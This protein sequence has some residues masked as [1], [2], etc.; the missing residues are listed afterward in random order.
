[1]LAVHLLSEL[2]LAVSH[3]HLWLDSHW[4]CIH[5]KKISSRPVLFTD[6]LF[7]LRK[8]FWMFGRSFELCFLACRYCTAFSSTFNVMVLLDHACCFIFSSLF[9]ANEGHLVFWNFKLFFSFFWK[10]WIK[11][12]ILFNLFS[13]FLH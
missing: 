1:M 2:F 13:F 7:Y 4:R 8:L 6:L 3:F 10:S 12:S 5:V 11:C 9:F